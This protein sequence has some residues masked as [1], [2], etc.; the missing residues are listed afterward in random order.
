MELLCFGV[1]IIALCNDH[2]GVA[3]LALMVMSL[4]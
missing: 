2:P 1:A 4:S 3:L